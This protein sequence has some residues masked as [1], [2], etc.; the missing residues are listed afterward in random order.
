VH[1]AAQRLIQEYL[2]VPGMVDKLAWAQ[3]VAIYTLTPERF[4]T[5]LGKLCAGRGEKRWHDNPT[6]RSS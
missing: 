3:C 5:Q 6:I 4:R 1:S 2:A